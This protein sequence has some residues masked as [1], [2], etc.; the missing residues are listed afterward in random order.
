MVGQ[1]GIRAIGNGNGGVPVRKA[2]ELDLAASGVTI[3][4]SGVVKMYDGGNGNGRYRVTNQQPVVVSQQPA[5]T[6]QQQP[7]D[8]VVQ[9]TVS[10]QSDPTAHAKALAEGISDI[11]MYNGPY[12]SQ[13]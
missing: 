2:I 10:E 6:S 8:A 4:P 1:T 3:G 5:A 11:P 13:R 7:A 12:H 9:Q